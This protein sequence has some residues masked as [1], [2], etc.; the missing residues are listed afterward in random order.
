[1]SNKSTLELGQYW[2]VMS[3]SISKVPTGEKKLPPYTLSI[4][5]NFLA[6]STMFDTFYFNIFCSQTGKSGDQRKNVI[7]GNMS[8]ISQQT[9]GSV[10]AEEI[11]VPG[12]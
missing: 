6:V 8:A 1:M 9:I 12:N 10:I 4:N 11:R 2:C 3:I 7:S 5:H